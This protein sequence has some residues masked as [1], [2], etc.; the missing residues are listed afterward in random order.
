MLIKV[1]LEIRIVLFIMS[2]YKNKSNL[3]YIYKL[4]YKE[5][6]YKIYI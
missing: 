2:I 3:T 4:I 5:C 1:V 6:E